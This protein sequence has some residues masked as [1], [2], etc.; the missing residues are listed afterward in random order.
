ML[1]S[2]RN[3]FKVS[4]ADMR[5]SL[6]VYAMAIEHAKNLINVS[7]SFHQQDVLVFKRLKVSYSLFTG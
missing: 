2:N 7:D 5:N 4:R 1:N 6:A 3:T